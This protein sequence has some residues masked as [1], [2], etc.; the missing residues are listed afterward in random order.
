MLMAS[1]RQKKRSWQ[2]FAVCLCLRVLLPP[3]GRR[4]TLRLVRCE[5]K[6]I[7]VQKYLRSAF[8]SGLTLVVARRPSA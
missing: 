6:S 2:F 1:C 3:S 4:S 8:F 7:L 5:G